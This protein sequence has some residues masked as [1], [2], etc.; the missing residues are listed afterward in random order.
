MCVFKV[1]VKLVGGLFGRNCG[2]DFVVSLM[3]GIRRL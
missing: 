2:D 1:W 3:F